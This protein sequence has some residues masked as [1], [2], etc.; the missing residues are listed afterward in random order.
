MNYIKRVLNK[1]A[2]AVTLPFSRKLE[3]IYRKVGFSYMLPG[4]VK[5]SVVYGEPEIFRQY[6]A[7]YQLRFSL[8]LL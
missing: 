1:K 5:F 8:V 7:A 4:A 6:S 2:P 3:D